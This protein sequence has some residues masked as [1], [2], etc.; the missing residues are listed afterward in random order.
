MKNK[1]SAEEKQAYYMGLGAAIGYGR[2][3]KSAMNDMSPKVKESFKNG[4]E[5]GLQ[6]KTKLKVLKNKKGR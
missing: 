3:I 2:K 4:L 1:Y 6:N 5:L